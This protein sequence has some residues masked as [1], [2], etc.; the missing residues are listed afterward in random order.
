MS[1]DF[2]DRRVLGAVRP[3]D[4]LTG[5]AITA[6]LG[7]TASGLSFHRNARAL[8]VITGTDHPQ[9]RAHL[10]RFA[11]IPPTPAPGAARFTVRVVDPARR[12]LPRLATLDL[13]RDADPTHRGQA[14][15]LFTPVDVPLLPSAALPL[16]PWWSALRVRV[17]R[18]VDGRAVPVRGAYLRVWRL[19]DIDGDG[20]T[21]TDVLGLGMSDERGEALVAVPGLPAHTFVGSHGDDGDDS[22]DAPVT[23]ADLAATLDAI[24]DPADPW[25]LDPDALAARRIESGILAAA[26]GITLR[27]GQ[28]QALDLHL[29]PIP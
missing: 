22:P 27:A 20:D 6:P 1:L 29:Q 14:G 12:W 21:D 7:V 23:T 5:T 26:R 11:E 24:A 10:D 4:P 19:R 13:P 28:S 17:T 9:L 3:V 25:P 2:D 8:F 15:S 18:T 16:G